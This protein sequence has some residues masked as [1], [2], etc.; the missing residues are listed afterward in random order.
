MDEATRETIDYVTIADEY[1]E[2]QYYIFPYFEFRA[3]TKLVPEGKTLQL[4]TFYPFKGKA[5][6]HWWTDESKPAIYLY[7]QQPTQLNV[8]LNPAGYI[9]TSNPPYDPESG[10]DII[11]YPNGSLRTIDPKYGLRTTD[12]MYLF[13]ESKLERVYSTGEGFVI[14]GQDLVNF[15]TN[16]LPKLG[17]SLKEIADY[18]EYWMGRLDT[19][20]PYYYI[21][22]LDSA[23]I[24]Q[25]E[26]LTLTNLTINTPIIPD[27]VIRLRTLFEPLTTH[28]TVPQPTF[29]PP[30]P[31]QGFILVEWGGILLPLDK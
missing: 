4:G 22:F 17:L 5:R 13:Y 14:A 23:Q 12:Y 31:R 21:E 29:S 2:D 1:P 28:V 6:W 30:P 10:W 24:E 15:F 11:A 25:L 20:Q 7:P 16:T 9:T 18:I 8:K 19:N 27:T 26:P 3:T